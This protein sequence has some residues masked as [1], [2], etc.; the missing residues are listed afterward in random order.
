[1]VVITRKFQIITI[2]FCNTR[3]F[4]TQLPSPAFPTNITS[5]SFVLLPFFFHITTSTATAAFASQYHIAS[6]HSYLTHRT[7]AT[8]LPK[9][10]TYVLDIPNLNTLNGRCYFLST[11]SPLQRS[12]MLNFMALICGLLTQFFPIPAGYDAEVDTWWGIILTEVPALDL[13]LQDLK[14]FRAVSDQSPIYSSWL[15]S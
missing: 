3:D 8:Q 5:P 12:T 6:K 9:P 2:Y 11:C 15:W 1:M 4:S 13:F 14:W 10:V 7:T